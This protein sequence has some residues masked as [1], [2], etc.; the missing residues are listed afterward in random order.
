M[1]IRQ[2]LP[3][4]QSVGGLRRYQKS[5]D[6]LYDH[7]SLLPGELDRSNRLLFYVQLSSEENK[8]SHCRKLFRD[9]TLGEFLITYEERVEKIWLVVE[10][11]INYEDIEVK[12]I[13]K[14]S[15]LISWIHTVTFLKIRKSRLKKM[16]SNYKTELESK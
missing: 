15:Q 3:V 6:L 9:Q 12:D 1:P 2:V 11:I 8:P 5:I 16:I 13:P 4:K 7:L 14:G 10:S